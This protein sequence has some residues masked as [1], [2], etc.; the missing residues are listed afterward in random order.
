MPCYLLGN[1]EQRATT[2][3]LENSLAQEE[4]IQ[5]KLQ[6][7]YEMQ[8]QCTTAMDNNVMK[9]ITNIRSQL[10]NVTNQLLQIG[11]DFRVALIR[12][13]FYRL[14]SPMTQEDFFLKI[15]FSQYMS[16]SPMKA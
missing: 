16:H 5:E 12:L 11:N 10:E 2:L 4:V 6:E 7:T 13:K 14:K 9:L 1:Q 15:I 8:G 3:K